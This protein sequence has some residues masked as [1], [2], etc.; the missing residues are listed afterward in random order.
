MYFAKSITILITSIFAVAMANRFVSVPP[1]RQTSIDIIFIRIHK[2]SWRNRGWNNRM[3]GFLFH[4]L[5]HLDGD[6]SATLNHPKYRGFFFVQRATS[7]STF[8]TQGNRITNHCLAK[9]S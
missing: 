5:Q 6:L 9:M 1:L 3:D 4:I 2:G 7:G 8:E